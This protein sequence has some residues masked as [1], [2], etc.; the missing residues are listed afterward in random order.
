MLAITQLARQLVEDLTLGGA[1][2]T[3]LVRAVSP[4]TP[5]AGINNYFDPHTPPVQPMLVAGCSRV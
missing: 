2:E 4:G 3:L 5:P 1:S